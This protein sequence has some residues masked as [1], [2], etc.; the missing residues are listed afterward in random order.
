MD[1]RPLKVSEVNS[2]I[3]RVFLGDMI[4]SNLS[5][6]GEISNFKHHYS[7]HMYFNLKDE[8]GK[9]KAVMFKGDN[10]NLKFSLEDGMKVIATGY[11]SVYEKEGDYQLYVRHIKESGLGD[12]YKAF[13]EL[14]K[15]LEA[16]GMF[17]ESNKKPIPF[18]PRKIGVVTSSTGAAIRDIITVIKRRFPPCNILI[19]PSLVQGPQ[20]P[21]EICKGLNYL[22]NREDVD[23]IITGR[24]GGS[25]EELFA[26]NDEEV[27]RTIY[28]LKTPVI[29]A[30]GHETDFTIA[31]F[32]ADLR[33]PTPSAAAELSVPDA[34]HLTNDLKNKYNRLTKL[35]YKIMEDY[36]MK[37]EYLNQNLKF[38]SPI[39]QLKDKRQE[40][41]SLFRDLNYVM[42][43]KFM[44]KKSLLVS[45][46]NN[47]D[48]LNPLL[49]LDRG[50]GILIDKEGNLIKSVDDTAIDDEINILLKDGRIR[51]IVKSIDKGGLVGE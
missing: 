32:V 43:K 30:V 21:K 7:G 38:Y 10:E 23:L 36:K 3:K 12:L 2:Y 47:L 34:Y 24:G 14:K 5:V 35:I 4:L 25:I 11:V 18:M 31:D 46:K 22:D 39:N 41:D 9:I 40:I 42:E 13:E 16:E 44:D 28:K 8:K 29:S 50:C 26:F 19:Y 27:A 48:L 51:S 20:A 17:L 15:K 1:I 33:A 6:E 37:N 49:A 45:L